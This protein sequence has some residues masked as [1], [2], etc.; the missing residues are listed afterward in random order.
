[1]YMYVTTVG[2]APA[3]CIAIVCRLLRFIYFSGAGMA[4]SPSSTGDIM[5]PVSINH[6]CLVCN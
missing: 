3:V 1:M 4:V 5:S 2:W 6:D